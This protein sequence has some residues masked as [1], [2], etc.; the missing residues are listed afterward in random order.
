MDSVAKVS[1][2]VD[3]SRSSCVPLRFLLDSWRG[4]AYPTKLVF[5]GGPFV[6][7]SVLR[8]ALFV[9]LFGVSARGLAAS[10]VATTVAASGITSSSAVLNGL[11]TPNGEPTTGRFRYSSTNPGTCNDTF[12]TRV[13]AASGT[14]LGSGSSNVTYSITTT[15][16][17]PGTTYYFCAIVTNASATVYGSVLSFTIPAAPLVVTTGAMN[18]TSSSATLQGTATPLAA[19]TTGWFRYNTTNPGTCDDSFGSRTPSS[20][21]T[22]LG[23]GIV[24]VPY[25]Q[26][27]TGLAPGTTYYYCAIANNGRAMGIGWV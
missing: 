4:F 15:G 14:D 2:F 18:V 5:L 17:V 3:H 13:P 24:G 19:T 23:A 1:V 12:G 8:A 11:G 21:G 10:P 26:S 16:L 7:I 22:A 6:S 25:Q 9:L 27:I 20:G